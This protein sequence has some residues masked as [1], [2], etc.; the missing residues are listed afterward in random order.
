MHLSNQFFANGS[1]LRSRALL[2]RVT[3][4]P[5]ADTEVGFPEIA[6]DLLQARFRTVTANRASLYAESDCLISS[7]MS[8]GKSS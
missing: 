1:Q 6:I 5:E 4:E 8:L 7:R 2:D 3:G